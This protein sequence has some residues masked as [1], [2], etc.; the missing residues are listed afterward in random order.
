MMPLR[1]LLAL[2]VV[3][4]PLAAVAQPARAIDPAGSARMLEPAASPL[5]QPA[6]DPDAAALPL[7]A[8][9]APPSMD[10][11][12]DART[13]VCNRGDVFEMNFWGAQTFRV[14]STVDVEGR[15]YLPRVGYVDVA[16]RTLAEVRERMKGAAA[17]HLPGL[18][19]ELSLIEPRTFFVHVANDVARPGPILTRATER[20]SQALAKAGG[21]LPGGSRRRIVVLRHDG[22]RLPADLLLYQQT[23]D[24]KYD[25]TLLDGDVVQVPFEDLAVTVSGA[26]RRP[27]RYE[28]TGSRDLKEA[29][30]LAGGAANEATR[31]LPLQLIRR[32]AGDLSQRSLL[33]L[34]AGPDLP[35]LPL[36]RDDQ[37]IVPSIADLQR[38]VLVVGAIA[39]GPNNADEATTS[40]RVPYAEGDTVLA[41]IERAG[42]TTA[43]ADLPR[44]YVQRADGS[45]VGVDLDAL[46]VRRDRSADLP[47]R[48]SDI[49][50]V[51]SQR[52]TVRVEGAVLRPSAVTFNPRL[53]LLDYVAQAG[54][55]TRLS[56]GPEEMRLITARGQTLRYSDG[57][58]VGPGDTI[59]VPERNFSRAEVVQLVLS[60]AGI[61]LSGTALIITATR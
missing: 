43:A 17:R 22:T 45:I 4:C 48:I 31:E 57:L 38:S 58:K 27:G 5:A 32:G 10:Q 61:V 60:A 35:E 12:I 11:P 40:K 33:P 28:L 2:A 15:A 41:L 46:L 16:G 54:G 53:R 37:V 56:Q 42:G 6:A 52:Q 36:E 14:R 44:G 1:P 59:I 34:G 30:A 19:F 55:E 25:P 47:V 13:Y 18:Q 23:G 50:V 39:G 49:I 7:A 8:P 26:V 3:G 20:V 51:P 21:I 9:A 24:T 29:V